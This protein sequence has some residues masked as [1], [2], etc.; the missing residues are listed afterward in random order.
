MLSTC[1]RAAVLLN[2]TAGMALIHRLDKYGAVIGKCNF[3][4]GFFFHVF[5]VSHFQYVKYSRKIVKSQALSSTFFILH[6][7]EE[8]AE[9]G[10]IPL[11]LS[12]DCPHLSAGFIPALHTGLCLALLFLYFLFS[13]HKSLTFDT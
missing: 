3:K 5:Y 1:P 4:Y 7:V 12:G 10:V 11:P 8:R 13:S 2:D 9:V 6:R